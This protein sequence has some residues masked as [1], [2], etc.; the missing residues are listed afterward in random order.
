MIQ[1]SG[2]PYTVFGMKSIIAANAANSCLNLKKQKKRVLT[3][4]AELV[5]LENAC[6]ACSLKEGSFQLLS[7]AEIKTSQL[8]AGSHLASRLHSRAGFSL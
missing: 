6:K 1:A 2:S 5:D 7:L 3:L 4:K 8:T